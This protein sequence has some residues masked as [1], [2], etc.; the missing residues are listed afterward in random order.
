MGFFLGNQ[1][2]LR[3]AVRAGIEWE[4]TSCRL[5]ESPHW[6]L[7]IEA[8]DRNSGSDALW[9]PVV[10]CQRCGLCYTNPRPS[11]RSI[12]QFYAGDYR[13]HR[14]SRRRGNR[15]WWRRFRLSPRSSHKLRHLLPRQGRGRLLDFGCGGGRFLDQMQKRGWEVTGVDTS[16]AA[17]QRIRDELGLEAVAGSLPHAALTPYSF[18]AITM[19][20][21]LEHVHEPLRVLC[22]ARRLLVLGGTLIVSVPNIDSLP[23][24]W[25]GPAWFGLDLPR[26]LTHFTP[27]TLCSMLEKAGFVV[28]STQLIRHSDWLRSSVK[29]ADRLGQ[30]VPWQ[31]WLRTRAGSSLAAWYSY[32]SRQTDC[33]QTIAVN[34]C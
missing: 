16:A 28:R 7:L 5:C 12:G 1:G 31:R 4:E 23:Y 20:Q 32:W 13:P 24:R 9:F 26:H 14:I 17:V 11:P 3:P 10:Q 29:L 22:E 30:R 15:P 8:P 18:D 33:I 34:A 21:S 25:F 2:I 27:P 6:S 19:W